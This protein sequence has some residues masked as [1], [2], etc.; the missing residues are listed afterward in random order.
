MIILIRGLPYKVGVLVSSTAKFFT[1]R[2]VWISLGQFFDN[3][4]P[5]AVILRLQYASGCPRHRWQPIDWKT[6][7]GT[8]YVRSPGE[9]MPMLTIYKAVCCDNILGCETALC[10]VLYMHSHKLSFYTYMYFD[11]QLETLVTPWYGCISIVCKRGDNSYM[12]DTSVEHWLGKTS[13]P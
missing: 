2:D 11:S 1:P 9:V 5:Q 6:K 7:S 8:I 4:H 13:I 12:S 3:N 10:S